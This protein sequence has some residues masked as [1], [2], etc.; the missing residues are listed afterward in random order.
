MDINFNI[1]STIDVLGCLQGFIF[2]CILLYMGLTGRRSTLFLGIFVFL[3]AYANIDLILRDQ[4]F[5]VQYTDFLLL[6]RIGEWLLAPL[7]LIYVQQT[8]I[9]SR[10]PSFW[11]LI[12]GTLWFLIQLVFFFVLSPNQKQALTEQVWYQA[13]FSIGMVFSVAIIIYTHIFLKRHAEEVKNQYAYTARKELRW[14]RTFNIFAFILVLLHIAHPFVPDSFS[15]RLFF[16]LVHLFMIYWVSI[17]GCSQHKVAS[18]IAGTTSVDRSMGGAVKTEKSDE[19]ELMNEIDAY[20]RQTEPFVNGNLTVMDIA[21]AIQVHPR[22]ISQAINSEKNDNFNTYI[23]RYRIRKAEELLENKSAINLSIDGIG[24]EVGFQSKSA[25][26]SAFKKFTGT[27]P[28]QY[29]NKSAL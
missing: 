25:F 6:P 3:F 26:Y 22:R 23:N 18:F 14:A 29:K 2:G 1:I 12:P 19:H 5:Y 9:L 13:I 27:T 28:N 16:S 24:N 21:A 8:S 20:V 15:Y 11:T 7:F 17:K 10:R 4:N